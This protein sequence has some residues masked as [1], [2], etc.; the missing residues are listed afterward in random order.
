MKEDYVAVVESRLEN[1]IFNEQKLS[2]LFILTQKG[3]SE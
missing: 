1:W 2:L 3:W